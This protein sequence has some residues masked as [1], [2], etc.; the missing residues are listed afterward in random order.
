MVGNTTSGV[1]LKSK[2]LSLEEA[3]RMLP[4]LDKIAQDIMGTWDEIIRK[5][6]EL[7][8]LEKN[9][10][11]SPDEDDIQERKNELN[12]LI[13][14]INGYIREVEELGDVR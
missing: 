10:N 14:R 12:R 7:E 11:P 5:R 3:N 1:Q 2:I 4:L 6:T 8:C 13:D 9:P